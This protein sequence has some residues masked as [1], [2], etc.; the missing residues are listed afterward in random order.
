L[1]IEWRLNEWV[2]RQ[3]PRQLRIEHSTS[4]VDQAKVVVLFLTGE[5]QSNVLTD[6][7]CPAR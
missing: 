2:G 4:H 7:A 3:E 5:A 1:A 6:A